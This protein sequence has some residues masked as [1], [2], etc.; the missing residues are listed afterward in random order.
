VT[1]AF[2]AASE[3]EPVAMRHLLAAIRREHQKMGKLLIDA[4]EDSA[5]ANGRKA[6]GGQQRS[7]K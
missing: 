1:A 2:L 5:A 6:H 4:D 7:E 3:D